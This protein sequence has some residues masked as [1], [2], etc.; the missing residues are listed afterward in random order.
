MWPKA[1]I[2]SD[3]SVISSF[4]PRLMVSPEFLLRSCY[5]NSRKLWRDK[6]RIEI[7]FGPGWAK[8]T[9]TGLNETTRNHH[10]RL[11]DSPQSLLFSRERFTTV[12][13]TFARRWWGQS[14]KSYVNRGQGCAWV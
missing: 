4:S 9:Y 14:T 1:K 12:Q 13:L 10:N 2:L 8:R 3:D 6:L 11:S 5:R 7:E